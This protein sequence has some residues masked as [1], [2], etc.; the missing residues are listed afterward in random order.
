M[1][2]HNFAL[3]GVAGFV[4]PRH[5]HAIRATGN[6][7]VAACDPNDSVGVLDRYF[8]DAKFFTEVATKAGRNLTRD[9]LLDHVSHR[10]WAPNDRTVDVLVGRL[11]RKIE[12]DAKV[13]T[14]IVTVHGVGY[15]FTGR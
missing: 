13:P 11:R 5:L 15:L 12:R 2:P 7:L 3:L 9:S 6:R 8:L 14:L 1:S 4:A 10:D